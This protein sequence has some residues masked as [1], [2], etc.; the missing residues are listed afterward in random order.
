MTGDKFKGLEEYMEKTPNEINQVKTGSGIKA[1]Q[2][3]EKDTERWE[4]AIAVMER[5]ETDTVP[6][7]MTEI[8]ANEIADRHTFNNAHIVGGKEAI[9][10]HI[11]TTF[12]KT[13]TNAHTLQ[14][15]SNK[16]KELDD[17]N[18]YELKEG[19]ISSAERVSF[20]SARG[21]LINLFKTTFNWGHT[22]ATALVTKAA[23]L[24]PA[25]IKVTKAL[26]VLIIMSEWEKASKASGS[27]THTFRIYYKNP[28]VRVNWRKSLTTNQ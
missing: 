27:M 11:I 19:I 4:K 1:R 9:L 21:G 16:V 2:V 3:I 6:P 25:G 24:E 14:P 28:K 17:I 12:G 13:A 5:K 26:I 15:N 23:L 7:P 20:N 10:Q 22:A 18:L 8:E